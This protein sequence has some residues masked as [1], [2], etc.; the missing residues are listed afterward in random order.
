MRKKGKDKLLAALLALAQDPDVREAV[1]KI[2]KSGWGKTRNWWNKRA[3]R[4]KVPFA[5]G[6]KSAR[7]PRKKVNKTV[8]ARKPHQAKTIHRQKRRRNT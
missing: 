5:S 8:K 7:P 1:K 3:R 4:N 2:A 6:G